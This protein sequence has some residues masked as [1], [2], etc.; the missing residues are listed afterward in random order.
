MY[1]LFPPDGKLFE[2][3]DYGLSIVIDFI[4]FVIM[5]SYSINNF[6]TNKVAPSLYKTCVD[7]FL[8]LNFFI[9]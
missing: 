3:E 9:L 1:L 6:D 2:G 4:L 7:I 8:L 5:V